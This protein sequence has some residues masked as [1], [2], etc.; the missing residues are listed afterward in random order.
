MLSVLAERVCHCLLSSTQIPLLT[1]V[2][3]YIGQLEGDLAVK[4]KECSTLKSQN[5]AL[6]E[7]NERYR[8]LIQTLLRHPSFTPFIDDLSKDP[9]YL[10][11][12][13]P[14][15]PQPQQASA[16]PTPAPSVPSSAQPQNVQPQVNKQRPVQN[17]KHEGQPR[18]LSMIS[19]APVDLS[20]L[21]L[22]H[23][24]ANANG[25]FVQQNMPFDF[26]QPQIYAA[27][28]LP[29]GP[30]ALDLTLDL[31]KQNQDDDDFCFNGMNW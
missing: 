3:E 12:Q 21:N 1:F 5:N 24:N 29:Q 30:S 15:Q 13:Q 19:E 27:H 9:I 25:N 7:E 16:A 4:D 6:T 8:A 23:A 14:R 18:N 17:V 31:V 10:A 20:M 11:S 2:L 22:N 28:Q 26:S